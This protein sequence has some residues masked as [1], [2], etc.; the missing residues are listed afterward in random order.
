[1]VASGILSR[2]NGKFLGE[3]TVDRYRGA[4]IL[5]RIATRLNLM[6][7]AYLRKQKPPGDM[8]KD[9]WARIHVKTAL[10]LDVLHLSNT[11]F[12]GNEDLTRTEWQD[13]LDRLDILIHQIE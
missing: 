6:H 11:N 9:H 2:F 10:A 1:M 3:K 5:E 13:A 7:W 4:L 12:R 8:P